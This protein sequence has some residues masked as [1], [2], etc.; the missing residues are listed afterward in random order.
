MEK[1]LRGGYWGK[2]S[3]IGSNGS[4]FC[5]AV[6]LNKHL[7]FVKL[8]LQIDEQTALQAILYPIAIGYYM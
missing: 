7:S 5:K 8:Y 3:F 2:L 1:R 6:E 4:G